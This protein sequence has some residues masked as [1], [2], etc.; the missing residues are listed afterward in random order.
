MFQSAVVLLS[1]LPDLE[2]PLKNV[3]LAAVKGLVHHLFLLV[4][5]AE[6]NPY[7]IERPEWMEGNSKL[8]SEDQIKEVKDFQAKE[9]VLLEEKAKKVAVLE[10]EF[11]ALKANVDEAAQK[12]DESLQ[13]CGVLQAFRPGHD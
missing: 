2:I 11:R 6:A 4:S 12:F 8:F 1:H 13:V 10:S 9:K 7:A 3:S 5:Q